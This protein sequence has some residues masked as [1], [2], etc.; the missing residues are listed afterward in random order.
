MQTYYDNV[1]LETVKDNLVIGQFAEKKTV[2]LYRGKVIDF[3]RRFPIAH[4][5]TP[6]TEG[7][8]TQNQ[9]DFKGE[10]IQATIQKYAQ[11]AK[12]SRFASLTS[13]DPNL[14]TVAEEFGPP[15]RWVQRPSSRKSQAEPC[16]LFRT[17]GRSGVNAHSTP[18][19][20][21]G[22]AEPARLFGGECASW[23]QPSG[24]RTPGPGHARGGT[25]TTSAEYGREPAGATG[26]V[27]RTERREA[28]L[29]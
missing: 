18:H 6:I 21:N 20:A 9:T 15:G 11:W 29:P 4:T 25:G 2:P 23:L 14:R 5:T 8:E 7:N 16:R 13:R 1:F 12:Y 10:N 22:F 17:R 27:P 26:R 3:F 19:P 28:R 24:M